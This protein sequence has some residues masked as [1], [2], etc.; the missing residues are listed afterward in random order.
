MVVVVVGSGSRSSSRRDIL[1]VPWARAL[2]A[3][4]GS[5]CTTCNGQ[6]GTGGGPGLLLH[7]LQKQPPT[8]DS[9]L[10]THL[11]LQYNQLQLD[12]SYLICHLQQVQIHRGW[13][14]E[15]L[16][17]TCLNCNH[18]PLL[19]YYLNLTYLWLVLA[20]LLMGDYTVPLFKVA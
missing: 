17:T 20:I 11:F 6:L 18:P 9:H 4:R 10:G 7:L 2:S 1:E 14:K 3:T 5:F 13:S 12:S 16:C 15:I 19:L 8:I